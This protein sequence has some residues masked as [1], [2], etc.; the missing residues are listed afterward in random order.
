MSKYLTEVK[1]FQ[2][3][4][5]GGGGGYFLKHPVCCFYN[6]SCLHILIHRLYTVNVDVPVVL[7]IVIKIVS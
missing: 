1:I 7:C 6:V 3:V 5:F 4:F 2:K